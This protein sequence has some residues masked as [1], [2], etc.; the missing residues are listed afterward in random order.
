MGDLNRAASKQGFFS[1]ADINPAI[2]QLNNAHYLLFRG[3]WPV[4]SA[5]S[6]HC[7]P[8]FSPRHF[9]RSVWPAAET[10]ITLLSGLLFGVL[11]ALG[12]LHIDFTPGHYDLTLGYPVVNS[13]TA[14]ASVF[15]VSRFAH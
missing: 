13:L 2:G 10:T 15:R 12:C 5:G 9:K 8:C 1:T 11:V 7:R 3:W 4:P 6:F 14:Y